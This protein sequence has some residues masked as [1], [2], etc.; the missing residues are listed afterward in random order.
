RLLRTG[1]LLR[2]SVRA[3]PPSRPR[4][5]ARRQDPRRGVH[6]LGRSPPGLAPPCGVGRPLTSG[7]GR[8][9]R[10]PREERRHGRAPPHHRAH[11]LPRRSEPGSGD[12]GR[13]GPGR[14]RHGLLTELL[15]RGDAP[16]PRARRPRRA[17]HARRGAD[18]GY[19]ERGACGRPRGRGHGRCGPARRFHGLPGPLRRPA[20]IP[21][22]RDSG[23]GFPSGK[24]DFS[25]DTPSVLL[26]RGAPL[27]A[28]EVAKMA[29]RVGKEQIKREK[30]YLYYLGKDGYLWKTPTKL[31]KSGKK[32]R[33]GTEKITRQDGYMYFLDKKGF[34]SR[35][36]MKNA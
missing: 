16:R 22:R 36:K 25:A 26:N 23:S 19:R 17:A 32:G 5:R 14:P 11:R 8:G 33:V 18:G 30:G 3:A 31:N 21:F 15:G 35:A 1:V 20:R 10:A 13:R 2:P 4:A 7:T 9:P 28:L 24:P 29:E 12:G 6:P 34:I 27:L